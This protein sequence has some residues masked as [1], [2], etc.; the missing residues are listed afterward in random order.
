MV[1]FHT[2]VLKRVKKLTRINAAHRQGKSSPAV[3]CPGSSFAKPNGIRPRLKDR[4]RP[5]VRYRVDNAQ[6]TAGNSRAVRPSV[7]VTRQTVKPYVRRHRPH[8]TRRSFVFLQAPQRCAVIRRTPSPGKRR[9][10]RLYAS[11]QS[12]ETVQPW[13]VPNAAARNGINACYVQTRQQNRYRRF[14]RQNAASTRSR[15]FT[16]NKRTCVAL[17]RMN[18][19]NRCAGRRWRGRAANARKTPWPPNPEQQQ[20]N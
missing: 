19:T 8:A 10:S 7:C 15:S 13:Y 2:E 1:V 12:I 18:T 14:S 16:N 6:T 17:R 5:A 11:A 4:G 3:V 9:S 20:K